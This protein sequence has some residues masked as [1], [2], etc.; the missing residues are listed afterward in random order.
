M[1][2]ILA[3][4]W[5]VLTVDPSTMRD[6]IL[7][8]IGREEACIQFYRDLVRDISV[9]DQRISQSQCQRCYYL[10]M[11]NSYVGRPLARYFDAF[12]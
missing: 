3:H 8:S 5:E 2:S 4:Q 7:H 11:P 12:L 9:G 1:A 10:H 6:V